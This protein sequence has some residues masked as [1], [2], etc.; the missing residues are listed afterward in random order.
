MLSSTAVTTADLP[1]ARAGEA[2]DA[3]RSL[4]A[5]PVTAA[6]GAYAAWWFVGLLDIVLIPLAAVMALYLAR[7]RAT[8]VPRGFGVWLLFLLWVAGSVIMVEQGG[9]LIGF[10]Y[11]YLV[12]LSSTVVFVYVY[13]ARRHLSTQYVLGLLTTVWLLVVL[14][15]WAG[16]VYPAGVVRTPMAYVVDLL[17]SAIPNATSLLNNELVTHMVVRRFA[18][19][20]PGSFF[21]LSPR[22]VAPF[23]FTNNWGNVYSL[24]LP[25]VVAYGLRA[26]GWRKVV[27]LLAIPAS[28]APALLTLNRGMLIGIGLAMVYTSWRL[29][30]LGRPKPLA[31]LALGG[32]LIGALYFALPIQ[33][34]LDARLG[35]E[36]SSTET[37]ASL[38]QQSIDSVPESPVFG[39][40]VPQE[41]DPNGPP[42]GTQGQVWMILVTAGPVALVTSLGWLLLAVLQSR[43]RR[44]LYGFA[45]HVALLVSTFELFYYGVLPYGLPLMMVAAALALRP[46]DDVRPYAEAAQRPALPHLMPRNAQ[47][48]SPL[49]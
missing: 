45:A 9:A 22:P 11:R 43:R 19:Y 13:N 40:G 38:Y 44:D 37:R 8:R 14:G 16:V 7:S 34:R 33:E 12:Y 39:F 1:P 21:E 35:L 47:S 20:T 28:V 36:G 15:G 27:V 30:L 10:A 26:H 3:T 48:S 17:K 49:N 29:L 5:W 31:A 41:G 23:R 4:P 46:A 25:L 42:V 6:F 2:S 32:V 18:Q 24:L